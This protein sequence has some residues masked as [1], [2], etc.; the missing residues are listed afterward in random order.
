MNQRIHCPDFS[1]ISTKKKFRRLFSPF[2]PSSFFFSLIKFSRALFYSQMNETHQ[3]PG[4]WHDVMLTPYN[5]DTFS[6]LMSYNI[7]GLEAGSTYE[8]IVQAKNRYGWNEVSDLFQF[9]TRGNSDYDSK[10]SR[11]ILTT[12]PNRM[13]IRSVAV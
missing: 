10:W 12:N 5:G 3:Q 11:F 7:R 6:H 2:L 8:A 13:L 4:Q 1:L 9:N